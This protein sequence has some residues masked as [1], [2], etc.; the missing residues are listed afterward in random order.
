MLASLL[1]N[2]IGLDNDSG[3]GMSRILMFGTGALMVCSTLV[4]RRLKKKRAKEL[5]EFSRTVL[6]PI[7]C[8][9]TLTL[10]GVILLILTSASFSLWFASTGKFPEFPKIDNLYLSL[11][12]AYLHGSI[13]LL[14]Q[15]DPRLES[16]ADPYDS[17]ERENV[18]YLWDASY[19]QGKY[20]IY[21]GPVPALI[22]AAV[23]WMSKS[24]PPD[25]LIVILSFLG[26]EIILAGLLWKFRKRY[27]P[28]SPGISLVLFLLVVAFNLPGL[29][30]LIRPHQY[31]TS[32]LVGQMFLFLGL[33]LWYNWWEQD[34]PVWL[35]GAGLSWGLAVGCRYNLTISVAVFSLFTLVRLWK[36]YRWSSLL[37]QQ[38]ILLALPLGVC[39]LGL[40]W[41]NAARFGD[42]FQTGLAYQLTVQVHKG[43]Y[44]S[45]HYLL[46]NLYRY[47]LYPFRPA[48]VF[49]VIE[50]IMP[51]SIHLPAWA[52]L[53]PEMLY[54]QTLFGIL[55]T[56]PVFWLAVLGIFLRPWDPGRR[57]KGD[58]KRRSHYGVKVVDEWIVLLSAAGGLQFLFLLFYYYAAVR[59]WA[60][61]TWLFLMTLILIL[62]KLDSRLSRWAALRGVFWTFVL[63]MVT[64]TAFVGFFGSFSAP[65]EM[66]SVYNPEQLSSIA[67]RWNQVYQSPDVLGLLLR[68]VVQLFTIDWLF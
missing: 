38:S 45:F 50:P 21:W 34:K 39:A 61:F 12:E 3:W 57:E 22:L 66:F 25:Q 29:F 23:V 43:Q 53:L 7:L 14:E 8:S 49:P 40:G 20:Y 26:L 1:A 42:F 5:Q 15:P 58:G 56:L 18:P 13:S 60:D 52:V 16:L 27:F 64:W 47:L 51:E 46:P 4:L 37:W 48:G 11:S 2:Q 41:Y 59:F 68:K 63:L 9:E 19:F 31:E 65:P 33:L 6:Q 28:N 55:P 35:F 32:I 67:S 30:L 24:Q 54:D 17:Q 36:R 44:F 10:V 62:W